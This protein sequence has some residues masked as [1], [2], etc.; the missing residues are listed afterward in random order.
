MLSLLIGVKLL[1]VDR[2]IFDIYSD[3]GLAR[4]IGLY[5]NNSLTFQDDL[6]VRLYNIGAGVALDDVN[7]EQLDHPYAPSIAKPFHIVDEYEFDDKHTFHTSIDDKQMKDKKD[8]LTI[9]CVFGRDGVANDYG[10]GLFIFDDKIS[11]CSESFKYETM[12][13]SSVRKGDDSNYS[14]LIWSVIMLAAV[15]IASTIGYAVTKCWQFFK[16]ETFDHSEYTPLNVQ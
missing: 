5:T 11:S 6:K 13:F 12:T 7:T 2:Y 1:S 9:Q 3:T 4:G 10:D 15:F 8:W 16:S 14:P